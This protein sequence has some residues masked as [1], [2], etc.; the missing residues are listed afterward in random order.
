MKGEGG[1]RKRGT[2]KRG[3]GRGVEEI[4]NDTTTKQVTSTR[5]DLYQWPYVC[6]HS[7]Q[8]K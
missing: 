2:G 4:G 7:K 8:T 5:V 1:V 6:E 3:E